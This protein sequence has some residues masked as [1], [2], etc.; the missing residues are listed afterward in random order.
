MGVS[1]LDNKIQSYNFIAYRIFIA[2]VWTQSTFLPLVKAVFERIPVIG[3]MADAFIPV[4]ITLAAMAAMPWFWRRVK[5]KDILFY[6]GLVFVVLLSM[7]VFPKTMPFLS[8]NWSQILISAGLFYFVGVSFSFRESSKILFYCSIVSIISVFIFRMYQIRNGAAL[9]QDDM[10][11]AYKLLPSAMYL[12]YYASIK[13]KIK[14]W[15]V[16]LAVIPIMLIFGTRGPVLIIM[17][18]ITAIFA[19]KA[20]LGSGY[21]RFF[22]LLL[23]VAVVTIFFV[24][25]EIF[26]SILK[27]LSDLF[28]RMGFSSRIFDFY[29][30]GDFTQ[31]KGRQAL[32]EAAVEAIKASPVI[33]YGFTADRYLFGVYPHNMLLEIWCHFGIVLG[34]LIIISL[35]LLTIV[36]LL[37]IKGRDR[38]F[39]FVLMLAIMVFGKLM[40]SNSYTVEPYFYFLIGVYT[41]IIR[42][43][44]K[45]KRVERNNEE[46][47]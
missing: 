5:G 21:K 23:L 14:Y 36:A 7:I 6:T 30:A 37:K 12:L 17:L 20:I 40:L 9:V 27:G 31:S 43:P 28:E 26:I 24:N 44:L 42:K 15:I 22:I 33:G 35:L 10:D 13:E 16:S 29:L 46:I 11:T 47:D 39:N 32:A 34:S 8:Q 19:K 3:T 18:F 45:Q 2:L 1:R 38:L 41:S 25:E 4:S